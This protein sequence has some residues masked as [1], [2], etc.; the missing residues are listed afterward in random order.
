M[1]RTM[2]HMSISVNGVL[3]IKPRDFD[4]QF[5]GVVRDHTGKVM[6]TAEVRR[7]FEEARDKGYKV[8]PMNGKCEG[9]SYETG[10]PGHVIKPKIYTASKVKHA[11]TWK[12]LRSGGYEIVSTWIDEA[13]EGESTDRA[14]L[15]KRCI[16]ECKDADCVLIYTEPGEYLKGAFIEIGAALASD[17]EIYAVGPVLPDTSVFRSHP[18]W[19][20]HE[21]LV[22]ALAAI[23]ERF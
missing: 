1:G 18:R 20:Q 7:E 5:N 17:R 11:D 22:A 19:H 16:Q 21:S 14:D 8:L 10:C 15:A 9:F 4:Q 3:A 13:G 12:A 6:T 23:G 2:T